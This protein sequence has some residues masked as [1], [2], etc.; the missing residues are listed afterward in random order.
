[1]IV[2]IKLVYEIG[3]EQVWHTS[4]RTESHLVSWNFEFWLPSDL[5]TKIWLLKAD[6]VLKLAFLVY[7]YALLIDIYSLVDNCDLVVGDWHH[8]ICVLAQIK[9]LHGLWINVP[10]EWLQL[11]VRLEAKQLKEE[12]EAQYA[13]AAD[14]RIIIRITPILMWC[15]LHYFE[16]VNIRPLLWFGQFDFNTFAL[17]LKQV[18]FELN[19]TVCLIIFALYILGLVFL[20]NSLEFCIINLKRFLFFKQRHGGRLFASEQTYWKLFTLVKIASVSDIFCI[21]PVNFILLHV[22]L[23]RMFCLKLSIEHFA[24]DHG[25]CQKIVSPIKCGEKAILLPPN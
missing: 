6:W 1:M 9:S 22:V 11:F 25:P 3:W 13:F 12:M 15:K 5:L 4:L 14:F 10:L 21:W 18:T 8:T 16:M 7:R 17:S 24:S 19:N 20:L 2:E 23:T